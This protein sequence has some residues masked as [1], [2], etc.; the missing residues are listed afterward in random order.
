MDPV[1][2]LHRITVALSNAHKAMA[3]IL[4]V[5]QSRGDEWMDLTQSVDRLIF[6]DSD[7]IRTR[8][9]RDYKASLQGRIEALIWEWC[10][11]EDCEPSAG[12]VTDLVVESVDEI[13]SLLKKKKEDDPEAIG[14]KREYIIRYA[15]RLVGD[16][17][18]MAISEEDARDRFNDILAEEE[19]DWSD[20]VV[21]AV[22]IDKVRLS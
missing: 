1:A 6:L 22:T 9:E 18:V 16:R 12:Q 20:C 7:E 10:E 3:S 19:D 11:R 21:D 15:V 13:L 2:D 17:A 8:A 14:A 4:T 5:E